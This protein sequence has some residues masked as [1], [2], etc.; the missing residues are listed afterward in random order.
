MKRKK[1][2]EIFEQLSI[3]LVEFQRWLIVTIL[4]S[5]P[6]RMMSRTRCW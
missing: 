4:P 5:L 1:Y 2:E 6:L 3:E